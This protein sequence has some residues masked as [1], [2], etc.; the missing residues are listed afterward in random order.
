MIPRKT[1][2]CYSMHNEQKNPENRI[3]FASL[4]A[5][6]EV[7]IYSI[8]VCVYANL[9][10]LSVYLSVCQSVCLSAR[11]P[12]CPSARVSVCP[13]IYLL[14]MDQKNHRQ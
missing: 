13:S 7:Y 2:S 9:F 14:A 1:E 3:A 6:F 10:C 11:V 5:Y 8:H 4:E 12:V